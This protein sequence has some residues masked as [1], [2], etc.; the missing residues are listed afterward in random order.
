MGHFTGQ[1]FEEEALVGRAQGVGVAESELELG[2][3]V[4]GVN[5]L[6]GNVGLVAGFPDRV[7]ETVGVN[8]GAGAV[9]VGAGRV[10]GLPATVAV[11]FEDECLEFDAHVGLVAQGGPVGDC[12]AQCAAGRNAEGTFFIRQVGDD[13]LGAGFPTGTNIV[14]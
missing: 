11:R 3:V 14:H 8:G 1:D 4:L 7:N 2:R 12:L 5:R 9:D 10:H 6:E 13:H